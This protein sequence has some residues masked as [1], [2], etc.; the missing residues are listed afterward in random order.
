MLQLQCR[1]EASEPVQTA[2]AKRP[3]IPNRAPREAENR[4]PEAAA[5]VAQKAI[6]DAG[7]PGVGALSR[8]ICFLSSCFLF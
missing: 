1:T 4:A 5:A 7:A 3:E 2:K 6:T 8:E